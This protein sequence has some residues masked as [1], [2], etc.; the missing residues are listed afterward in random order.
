[1][2]WL[3]YREFKGEVI[4]EAGRRITPRHIRQMQKDGKLDAE[5]RREY[6]VGKAIA[7]DVVE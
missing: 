6:L 4:V 5:S 2:T 3:R 1:M 7:K